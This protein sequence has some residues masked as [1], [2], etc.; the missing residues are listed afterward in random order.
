MLPG[1]GQAQ[2]TNIPP[3]LLRLVRHAGIR[4]VSG[5]QSIDKSALVRGVYLTA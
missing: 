5:G 3:T 1:W 4:I 2:N